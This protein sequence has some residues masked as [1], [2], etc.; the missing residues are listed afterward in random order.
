VDLSGGGTLPTMAEEAAA[1][2]QLPPEQARE[3]VDA[4]A[5]VVDVRTAVE[6]AESH[7]SGAT[8][9]PLDRLG[10]DSA[11]AL[12]SGRPVLVYCRGGNRSEAA[13]EALRNS[14]YDAHSVDGGLV[15]WDEAGLPLEPDGASIAAAQN[16]PP[17]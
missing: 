10:A 7:I 15:A 13:A 4:G 12:D 2:V 8:H 17:R 16:L 9:I 5:Q 1:T 6:H 3:L 14:G 11:E